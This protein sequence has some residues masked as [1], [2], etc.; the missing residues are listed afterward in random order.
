M[1]K[2]SANP[3][4]ANIRAMRVKTVL[5]CDMSKSGSVTKKK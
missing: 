2:Q 5:G 4:V 1:S 3:K